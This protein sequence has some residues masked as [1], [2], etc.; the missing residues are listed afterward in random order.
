MSINDV[1]DQIEEL[2]DAVDDYDKV[3]DFMDRLEDLR[4]GQNV[5]PEEISN[6]LADIL[7]YLIGKVP[8][9]PYKLLIDAVI[10]FIKKAIDSNVK[11]VLF[12]LWN[13]Y[14]AL[15]ENGMDHE[16]AAENTTQDPMVEKYLRLKWIE[17]KSS[18]KKEEKEGDEEDE[19]IHAPVEDGITFPIGPAWS[20]FYNDCCNTQESGVIRGKIPP[21]ISI[22]TP[23][24]KPFLHSSGTSRP[25][26]ISFSAKHGCGISRRKIRVFVRASNS[27]TSKWLELK[28]SSH[29]MKVSTKS[30]GVATVSIIASLY[31]KIIITA[32]SNCMTRKRVIKDYVSP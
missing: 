6:L 26:S 15:R 18:D 30:N 32:K 16:E 9:G 3:E 8:L 14:K 7:E 12:I 27:S 24:W 4:N 19:D 28:R 21:V 25:F 2:I 29:M 13:K 10:K 20:K 17:H 5:D 23:T 11:L 1:L 31:V 22:D